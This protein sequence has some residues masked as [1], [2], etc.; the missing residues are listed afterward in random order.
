MY[1]IDPRNM[2]MRVKIQFTFVVK[3]GGQGQ[4][5]LADIKGW[6]WQLITNIKTRW[7]RVRASS[8]V[9]TSKNKNLYNVP[10]FTL[11][12]YIIS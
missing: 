5:K 12:I 2:T 6:S 10:S 9:N 1:E 11:I 8:T 7:Q 4:R 3:Q